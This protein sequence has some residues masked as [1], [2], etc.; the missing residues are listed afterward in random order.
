VNVTLTPELE[1]L[2]Q[3]KVERGQYESRDAVVRAA[4][5]LFRE[6]EAAQDRLDALL[7]EAEGEGIELTAEARSEIEKRAV[8]ALR[9][10]K[11][12]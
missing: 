10:R 5:E 11:P 1:K 4:L 8:S 3:T 9:E 12:A 7:D 2:I 6:Q